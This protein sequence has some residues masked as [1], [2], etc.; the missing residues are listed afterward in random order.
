MSWKNLALYNVN[1]VQIMVELDKKY[2]IIDLYD[3]IR[4]LIGS[5]WNYFYSLEVGISNKRMIDT[6]LLR[7]AKRLGIVLPTAKN[8]V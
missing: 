6:L 7:E 1:D 2:H 8:Y 5:P 4:R 3:E